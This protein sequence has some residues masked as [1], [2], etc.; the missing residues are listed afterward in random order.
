MKK[1]LSILLIVA[2][3]ANVY[4]DD[5]TSASSKDENSASFFTAISATYSMLNA[6][7]TVDNKTDNNDMHGITFGPMFHVPFTNH[8]VSFF[9]FQYQFGIAKIEKYGIMTTGVEHDIKVPFKLGYS[10]DFGENNQFSIF[11]GPSF[12]FCVSEK[13]EIKYGSYT[14]EYDYISGKYK[15]YNKGSHKEGKS[16]DYKTMNVFD[17]QLGLGALL[18]FGSFGLRVEYDWGMLNRYKES[19]DVKSN[20]GQLTAGLFVSF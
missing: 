13:A 8:F 16:D 12:L 6:K 3:T 5:N 1:L 15:V 2:I 9:G 4:A 14:N 10:L 19:A 17:L 20:V 18:R 7:T 11:A